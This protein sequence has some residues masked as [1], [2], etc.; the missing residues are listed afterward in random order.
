MIPKYQETSYR[1]KSGPS[2]S[3]LLFLLFFGMLFPIRA[4]VIPDKVFAASH[5]SIRSIEKKLDAREREMRNLKLRLAKNKDRLKRYKGRRLKLK[6]RILRLR[7][8]L[9]SFHLQVERL[10]IREI[11]D[12][13]AI[14]RLDRAMARLDVVVDADLREKGSLESRLLTRMAEV[15]L[16]RLDG[17][18]IQPDLILRSNILADQTNHLDSLLHGYRTKENR[19]RL[20]RAQ[21]KT[22]QNHEKKLLENREEEEARLKRKMTGTQSEIARL[23]KKEEA[24]AQDNRSI[25]RR[26]RK[27]M[28]LIARLERM[29]RRSPLQEGFSH[30]PVPGHSVFKW[31]VKGRIIESFGPFHDGIDI[32]AGVGSRVLAAWPGKV[33]FARAYAGYG[34]LVILAHGNHLYT[35]Y[36]HLDHIFAR[37]GERVPE[38]RMI[39]TVGRGGTRGRSTLFFGVT[40]RGKPISPM[41]FLSH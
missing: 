29:R 38:G 16:S 27:L 25:L 20:S 36:G 3:A 41:G 39:G 8:K 33:L 11:Q 19:L 32:A 34:R 6:V 31:P 5:P 17:T 14:R 35:L 9:E 13:Q 23:K 12:R 1:R 24:I 21:L 28:N 26:R 4:G 2:G 37:E 7:V 22:I 10:Q 30:P 18:D 15:S 40:R